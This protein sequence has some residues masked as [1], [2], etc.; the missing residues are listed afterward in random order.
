M[1]QVVSDLS[2]TSAPKLLPLQPSYSALHPLLLLQVVSD[3]SVTSAPEFRAI[4]VTAEQ[5]QPMLAVPGET[6]LDSPA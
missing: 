4:S 6:K 3:L 1:L 2:V 5:W